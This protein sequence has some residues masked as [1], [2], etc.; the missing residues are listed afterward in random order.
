M[1]T[2]VKAAGKF[3]I[4]QYHITADVQKNGDVEYTQRLKYHFDGD[5]HGVYYNQNLKGIT[6]YSKPQVAIDTG[7]QTIHLKESNT[8][9]DNTYKITKS[10]NTLGIKVYHE[11]DA[12]NVTFI[13]KYWLSGIVVN[14]LDTAV[15]NWKV[16][17]D[18]DNV[19]NNVQIKINLPQS[20]LTNL[21]A[22]TYGPLDGKNVVSK[23]K[24]QVIATVAEVPANMSVES[25]LLFPTSVTSDNQHV[26]KKNIKSK[27]LAQEKKLAENANASRMRQKVI[28]YVVMILGLGII[29]GIYCYKF[30]T[31]FKGRQKHKIPTPLYHSFDAPK[32]LP[33]FTKVLLERQS[34]AD[35]Q[36]LT[37]DLMD[38]VGH[39]R[40]RID[41]VGKTYEITA[42]VPPTNEFF[43]YLINDIGDGKKVTLKQIRTEAKNFD[44]SISSKFDLW[45]EDAAKGREKYLDQKNMDQVDGFKISAITTDVIAFILFIV[46]MMFYTNIAVMGVVLVVIAIVPWVIYWW[47]NHITAQYT[48]EGEETVNQIR[49]F[50]RMLEDIDDIKLSEV[51]D[52][53]LW[54]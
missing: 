36:S 2:T 52:I 8:G 6:S 50:K 30:I 45:A 23:K 41:Q 26:V 53:I 34:E 46:N 10:A 37:A 47:I 48:D 35:S 9:K 24:G 12:G 13:Y 39:R 22:W 14:Y 29:I 31:Y 15:M 1:P 28:Y 49:A 44:S 43:K 33:S 11:I 32:F 27:V 21:Q 3:Q 25:R 38:E 42:L 18:W 51:G 5:F 19:L 4:K 40:M 54:E 16:I 20:N 17:D 7:Y